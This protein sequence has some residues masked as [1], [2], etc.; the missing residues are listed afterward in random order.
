MVNQGPSRGCHTCKARR[1][2]CDEGRPTCCHCRRLGYICGGYERKP[3]KLRF[4]VQVAAG[5]QRQQNTGAVASAVAAPSLARSP[6]YP[7]P[8]LAMGFFFTYFVDAG[9][10][11]ASTRG[12]FEAL[13]PILA[14]EAKDS[15]ATT[16]VTALAT[17]MLSLWRGDAQSFTAPHKPLGVALARLGSALQTQE[18][19]VSRATPFAALVM[20]F[21][22]NMNAIYGFR[23]VNRTHHDGAVA[24]LMQ[25]DLSISDGEIGIHV[26]RRILHCE[27]SYR[28]HSGTAFPANM[29]EWLKRNLVVQNPSTILDTIGISIAN[30]QHAFTRLRQQPTPESWR[31]VEILLAEIETTETLLR[32]WPSVLPNHWAPVT[33]PA[34]P[35]AVPPIPTYA[36]RCDIYP[37]SQ[38]AA[39]WNIWRCHQLILLKIRLAALDYKA[40]SE[41]SEYHPPTTLMRGTRERVQELVDAV[42]HSIPFYVGN[43]YKRGAL[44]DLTNPTILHTSYFDLDPSSEQFLK[45]KASDNYMSS[46]AHRGHIVVQGPWHMMTCL[47]A[48][49]NLLSGN[50]EG[51]LLLA[52]ALRPGQLNWMRKQFV[53]TAALVAIELPVKQQPLAHDVALLAG[54]VS[55]GLKMASGS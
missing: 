55:E 18:E 22:E 43:R 37:A 24:L 48:V 6:G 45:Y 4:K 12:F 14:T 2:R 49:I 26:V 1:V 40:R 9:R 54:K 51:S 53:R 23:E 47:S 10:T 34:V 29:E 42:C 11:L 50:D 8:D 32:E 31:A 13:P 20:Q 21:Y 3:P 30:I 36:G 16:A 15:A 52:R 44:S 46:E 28:L 19:R 39:I 35:D 41:P 33:L 38:V 27:V 7:E 5:P 25:H 17:R